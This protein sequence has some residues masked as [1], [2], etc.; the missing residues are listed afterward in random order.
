M[1]CHV[2][3]H[4]HHG[5]RLYAATYHT[6]G[7]ALWD[8]SHRCRACPLKQD[9]SKVRLMNVM[10]MKR[11]ACNKVFLAILTQYRYCIALWDLIHRLKEMD[12]QDFFAIGSGEVPWIQP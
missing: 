11:L 7:R 12:I 1:R 3:R 5:V 10:A 2:R 9:G 4:A 6:M 8:V